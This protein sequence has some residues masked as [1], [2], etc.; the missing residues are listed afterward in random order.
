MTR[1]CGVCGRATMEIM[2]P[3]ERKKGVQMV[4]TKCYKI[5]K[6]PGTEWKEPILPRR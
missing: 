3:V 5:E 6:N 4:C 1:K 2:I